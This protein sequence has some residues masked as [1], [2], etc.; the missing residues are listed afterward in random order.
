M[1][2]MIMIVI[3]LQFY[4]ARFVQPDVGNYLQ[5]YHTIG[6]AGAPVILPNGQTPSPFLFLECVCDTFGE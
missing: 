5:L 3:G 4:T 2:S 1:V 6:A